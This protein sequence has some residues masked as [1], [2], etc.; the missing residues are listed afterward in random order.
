MPLHPGRAFF[1][2]DCTCS[3]CTCWELPLLAGSSCLDVVKGARYLMV[4]EILS[5][6]HQ[7]EV[8]PDSVEKAAFVY[9][10]EQ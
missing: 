7:V 6:H 4:M 3:S 10:F 1:L 5:A 2:A 9:K 8:E